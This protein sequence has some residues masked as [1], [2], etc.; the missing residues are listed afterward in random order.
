MERMQRP[1][2]SHGG[3]SSRVFPCRLIDSINTIFFLNVSFDPFWDLLG[4]IENG[5]AW[6]KDAE[7]NRI[8]LGLTLIN[9]HRCITRFINCGGVNWLFHV[10][11]YGVCSL[12]P[13]RRVARWEQWGQCPPLLFRT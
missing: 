8:L 1:W 12:F 7:K 6:V 4:I 2:P 3:S 13:V 9:S 10:L 5:N 11:H